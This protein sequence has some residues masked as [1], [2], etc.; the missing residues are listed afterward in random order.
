MPKYLIFFFSFG[1]LDADHFELIAAA[2]LLFCRAIT[3]R[4][5]QRYKK[6]GQMKQTV[7]VG[8]QAL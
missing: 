3:R 5:G 1:Q 2:T 7:S 8:E 4:C 6:A